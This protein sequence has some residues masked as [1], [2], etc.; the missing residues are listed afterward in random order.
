ML[1]KILVFIFVM[2]ATLS[3][4]ALDA[5]DQGDYVLLDRNGK[6]LAVQMRYRIS[7][8]QWIM[9]GKTGDEDWHPV[10][11]GTGQC[12]LVEAGKE[13]TDN[14][15]SLLPEESQNKQI[16]CQKNIAFAFCR[17]GTLENSEYWWFAF[18]KQ[19]RVVPIKLKRLN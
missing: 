1:K 6:P 19:R 17:M 16:T 18:D 4:Q 8:G 15:Q 11:H 9:D 12:R 10:C 3:V 13:D 14:W 7:N 2:F 5:G